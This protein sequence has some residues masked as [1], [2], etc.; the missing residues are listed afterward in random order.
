MKDHSVILTAAATSH[1]LIV[2]WVW[3]IMVVLRTH[4]KLPRHL[5]FKMT[6]SYWCNWKSVM[7]VRV[8]ILQWQAQGW[9]EWEGVV[10]KQLIYILCINVILNALK[11][12]DL[13][14]FLS[15]TI[16]LQ[17]LTLYL[18]SPIC[19]T[20]NLLAHLHWAT[21]LVTWDEKMWI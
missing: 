19:S 9:S 4:T 12:L 21:C 3:S 2:S 15:T 1:G 14:S 16:G 8:V 17:I 20:W 11:L 13:N 5:Y 6:K 10:I 18:F 7:L